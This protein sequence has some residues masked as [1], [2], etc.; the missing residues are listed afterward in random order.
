MKKIVGLLLLLAS[1]VSADSLKLSGEVFTWKTLLRQEG[2]TDN[3]W[4]G[5]I[6]G[7]LEGIPGRV[8]VVAR[9]DFSALRPFDISAPDI[10]A[11]KTFE[12]Y[13]GVHR[14]IY[15]NRITLGP[16]MVLGRLS[17]FDGEGQ[18]RVE[19]PSTAAGGIRIGYQR[20]WLYAMAGEHQVAGTGIRLILA[21]QIPIFSSFGI[22]GDYVSG[23]GGFFRLGATVK[24]PSPW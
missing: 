22:A 14:T 21:G 2:Q 18:L 12:S 17:T 5:R 3:T 19:H 23:S 10:S 7:R 4:G 1:Q 15:T 16:T 9:F 13:I 24:V 11:L 6:T 8:I 20:A